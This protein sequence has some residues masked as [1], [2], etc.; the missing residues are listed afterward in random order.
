MEEGKLEHPEEEKGKAKN[1]QQT[2]PTCDTEFGMQTWTTFG[3][4]ALSTFSLRTV[5]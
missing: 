3:R 4:W 5:S 1:Q 2:Q